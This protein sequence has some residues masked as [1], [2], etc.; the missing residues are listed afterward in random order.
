MATHTPLEAPMTGKTRWLAGGVIALVC[1]ALVIAGLLRY[2][3]AYTLM[4]KGSSSGA[5]LPAHVGNI[6]LLPGEQDWNGIPSFDFGV[7]D[8]VNWNAQLNMDVE[9]DAK[10]IQAAL[11][12]AGTPIARAWFFQ[13]SLIDGHALSDAEQLQKLHAVQAAGMVCFANFP[14]ENTVAYDLHLMA[15]LDPPGHVNCPYVE[16]MN[17]PDIETA[18]WNDNQQIDPAAY[19]RFWNAFVPQARAGYHGVLFGGPAEYNNQGDYCT[20][21]TD[22]TSACFLQKVMQGM[23]ASGNRADFITYHWYPCW[24]ENADQCLGSANTFA[25]AAQQVIAWTKQYFGHPLPV[26][27]SEWNADPGSP[28]FMFDR[29]WDARYVSAALRSI[30]SSG[31]SGAMEMDVSQYGNYGALDLFDI[32]T[33][34][35]FATW[36]AFA[37][38]VSQARRDPSSAP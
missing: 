18:P 30:A 5:Q 28:K 14:T 11:K 10:P 36:N 35:P 2:T 4:S 7:N 12:A 13:T 1:V 37:T 6:P 16:V 25:G 21:N 27:C 32:S 3:L 15:L 31:L 26:I 8:G 34:K 9:P 19:L 29:Q 24:Q 38:I 20:Y 22:G 23:V 33:G 17:E